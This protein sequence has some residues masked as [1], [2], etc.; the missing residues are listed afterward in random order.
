VAQAAAALQA[1]QAAVSPVL[2][3]LLVPQA[4]SRPRADAPVLRA[5][6]AQAA[7]SRPAVFA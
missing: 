5:L 3:W 7:R 1:W 2:P 4:Y 6:L